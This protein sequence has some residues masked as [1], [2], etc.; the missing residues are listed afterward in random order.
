M[1]KLARRVFSQI[2]LAAKSGQNF[3]HL[4][5]LLVPLVKI[6]EV[7]VYL[8]SIDFELLFDILIHKSA[9]FN[10]EFLSE[11]ESSLFSPIRSAS[12]SLSSQKSADSTA[13]QPNMLSRTSLTIEIA[14]GFYSS[15]VCPLMVIDRLKQPNFWCDLFEQVSGI[16][17]YNKLASA[18]V[19]YSKF[20]PDIIK[21][22]LDVLKIQVT[23]YK[24]VLFLFKSLLIEFAEN[25]I[26]GVIRVLENAL[27]S[28]SF[29]YGFFDLLVHFFAEVYLFVPATV[30]DI[31]RTS[32]VISRIRSLNKETG[33]VTG[34]LDQ[35]VSLLVQ[36]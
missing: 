15:L 22:L 31:G 27:S 8:R 13:S 10:P 33:S 35:N 4:L 11:S 1:N 2:G 30:K 23:N 3:E 25:V 12:D 9:K 28:S 5:L 21:K 29:H 24:A 17:A 18:F 26:P 6:R 19:L 14:C 16:P 32:K 34:L 20:N 36:S 7:N